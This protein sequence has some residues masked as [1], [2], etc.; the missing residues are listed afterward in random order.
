MPAADDAP[1]LTI[2]SRADLRAWLQENHASSKA[3]WLAS[4]KKHH[5]DYLAYEPQV[6]E[7][8]CWGWIDS[9]TRALDADRSM[10][11]IAPRNPKSAWSA[12][13][14]AHVERARASGAMTPAGEAKIAIAIANGQWDFLNDVDAL[15]APEDLL[16]AL[17]ASGQ[18]AF[19]DAIPRSV[20]RGTLEWIKTAK[21]PETRQKRI[22]DVTDSAALGLRPSPFRR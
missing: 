4:Y 14:K 6:A 5:P 21:S 19:W 15:I 8:L 11:L 20:K 17:D 2:R 10:I 18:R 7:L 9:V 22:T 3:V 13:N 16:A 12:L 1:I